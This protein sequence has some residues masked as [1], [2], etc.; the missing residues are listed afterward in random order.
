MV[1][2]IQIRPYLPGDVDSIYEAVIESRAELAPWMPWCHAE[3]SKSDT[4][5]WVESRPGAGERNE[6]CSFVIVDVTG[7]IMG[8]CG[9]HGFD[10]RNKTA[11]IGYW[12]RTSATRQGIAS[13]A[14][15]Q[16]AQWAFRE[17]GIHR[18]EIIAAVENIGSHRVA[19]KAGAIRE[20]VLRERLLL[21]G[22]RHDG[23][24]FALLNE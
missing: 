17:Q 11:E 22:K 19:E 24:L 5:G 7:R 12:V 9:V 20:G 21:D 4:L 3:Y 2:R 16:L 6:E 13:A 14:A 1:S 8:A 18:I 15:R 23:V 10:L